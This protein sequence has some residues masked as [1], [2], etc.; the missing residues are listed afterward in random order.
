MN[1]T[2]WE[3][4]SSKKLHAKVPRANWVEEILG[5]SHPESRRQA[6]EQWDKL[7]NGEEVKL[8]QVSL[9]TVCIPLSNRWRLKGETYST[10]YPW[11]C[12]VWF[13]FGQFE[14]TEKQVIVWLISRM[15][16]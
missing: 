16:R 4:G 7:G 5:V 10:W 12:W 9:C 13:L 1:Y 2:V 15:Q 14:A 6:G 3:E 8:S 11:Q